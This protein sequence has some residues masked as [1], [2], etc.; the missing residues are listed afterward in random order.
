M[1]LPGPS[2]TFDV[3]PCICLRNLVWNC[4]GRTVGRG[5]STSMC[6]VPLPVMVAVVVLVMTVFAVVAS[7]AFDG[8]DGGGSG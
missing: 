2:G 3:P 8:G 4:G 5:H 7:P 6:V 1:P